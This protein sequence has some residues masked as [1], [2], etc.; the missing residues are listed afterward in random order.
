MSR[1]QDGAESTRV[2]TQTDVFYAQVE[3]VD[4]ADPV[5]IKAV[6]TG[7]QIEGEAPDIFLYESEFTTGSGGLYFELSN[8]ELWPLGRYKVDIYLDGVLG[9][10]LEFEV[11]ADETGGSAANDLIRAA[12]MTRN[13]DSAEPT[14]VFAPGDV[15]YAV[16]ELAGAP[17]DTLLEADWYVVQAEGFEPDEFLDAAEITGGDDVYTF[18]LSY[19][20]PWPVG[21]YLVEI[22]LNGEWALTLE[23][24]VQ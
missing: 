17:D 18:N 8:S 5:T 23:F 11:Q 21:A 2:F 13:P 16:I 6:W 22:Y 7:V 10:T 24:E 15:F 3:L 19:T 12:Y 1:D 14:T 20:G 4:A 9:R